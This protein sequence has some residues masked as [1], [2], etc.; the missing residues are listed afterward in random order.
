MSE[1]QMLAV[2]SDIPIPKKARGAILAP[3]PRKYPF[4]QMEVGQMFFVPNKQKNTMNTYFSNAGKK[5]GRKFSTRLIY[6]RPEGDVWA[7]CEATD[8]G[9]VR[10]IGVWRTA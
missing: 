5:L 2:I 1:T 3:K 9:A 7:M 4:E 10:G 8:E 6:M